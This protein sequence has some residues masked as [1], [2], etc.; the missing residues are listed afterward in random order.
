[1]KRSTGSVTG[2]RPR[3]K[4][5]SLEIKLFLAIFGVTLACVLSFAL[6]SNYLVHREFERAFQGNEF[7]FQ[8]PPD[9]PQI[10]PP[11]VEAARA[12]RL[13]DINLSY[14]SGLHPEFLS[15]EQDIQATIRAHLG[16]PQYRWRRIRRTGRG[17]RR[18][19]G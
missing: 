9:L 16:H 2:S 8:P 19:G 10:L 13:R 7:A 5:L 3:R 15:L 1:M 18:K 4:R 6:L 11:D 17:G 12:E 14:Y